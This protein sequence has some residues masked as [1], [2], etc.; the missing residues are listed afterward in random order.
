MIRYV[1]SVMDVM[2]VMEVTD[3]TDIIKWKKC[4]GMWRKWRNVTE[5]TECDGFFNI[6]VSL[7]SEWWIFV[8]ISIV[9]SFVM[10][11]QLI[12]YTFSRNKAILSI[13]F[14]TWQTVCDQ[15]P[16]LLWELQS[17][18]KKYFQYK[19]S[20]NNDQNERMIA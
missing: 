9:M 18:Q 19:F 5:V 1:M 13:D 15:K 20:R 12:F 8:Y 14:S 10:Y 6:L 4:D 17:S 11:V 16:F 2:E 3:V 7:D